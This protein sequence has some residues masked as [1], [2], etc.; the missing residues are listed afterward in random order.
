LFCIKQNPAQKTILI[1]AQEAYDKGCKLSIDLNMLKLWK[2]QKKAFKVI[3]TYC[4]FNPL[5]KISEDDMLRLLRKSYP[6][7]RY[8]S[9]S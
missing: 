1:K 7:K 2:S 9:F 6:M 3:K 8:S 4:Q 5:I